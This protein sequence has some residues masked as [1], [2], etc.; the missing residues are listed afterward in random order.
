MSRLIPVCSRIDVRLESSHLINVAITIGTPAA[1]SGDVI[2]RY[3]QHN[4]PLDFVEAVRHW[5]S[6]C[7]SHQV[8]SRTLSG[9]RT[10]DTARTPLPKRCIRISAS[11]NFGE[12]KQLTLEETE[13]GRGRYICVTHRWVNPDTQLS[14]TTTLNY[15]D[16]ISGSGFVHVPPHFRFIFLAAAR[17]GIPYVWIDCLCIIQDSAEDWEAESIKMGEYYQLAT[18]TLTTAGFLPGQDLFTEYRPPPINEIARLPYRNKDGV[19]TGYL[20]LYPCT[21]RERLHEIYDNHLVDSQLLTRGWVFQEWLLSRRLICVTPSGVFLQC[22]CPEE[23]VSNQLGEMAGP[24]PSLDLTAALCIKASLRLQLE[25]PSDS[26][27]AWE[28][29]VELYSKMK[30]SRPCDDRVI[31]LQSIAKEIRNALERTP[32]HAKLKKGEDDFI[33]GLWRNELSRGLLWEQV[34][35]GN[36]ERLVRFPTWSWASINTAVRWQPRYQMVKASPLVEFILADVRE[37]R[38]N[39]TSSTFTARRR[40]M[41]K[42]VRRII[43]APEKGLIGA[44][45]PCSIYGVAHRPCW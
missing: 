45:L 18:F 10:I 44:T 17:L 3:I 31:A 26:Y 9:N 22:Q 41:R 42:A 4:S 36:H 34:T 28:S 37:G 33:A 21:P 39:F 24:L 2:G 11:G 1:I 25:S 30:L 5:S 12:V 40:R 19:R 38:R 20:Y 27:R 29:M 7:S 8:C 32:C 43:P 13:G 16:R 14:S 15:R 23:V 6:S 35:G